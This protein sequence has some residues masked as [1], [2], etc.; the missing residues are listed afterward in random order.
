MEAALQ[1]AAAMEAAGG[2]QLVLLPR[3]DTTAGSSTGEGNARALGRMV[4][5]HL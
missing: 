5:A 3:T 1:E 4:Q 2:V